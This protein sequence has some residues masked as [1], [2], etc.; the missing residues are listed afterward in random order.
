MIDVWRNLS[1]YD[2]E[3]S[4]NFYERFIFE[5]LAR[6]VVVDLNTELNLIYFD[7]SQYMNNRKSNVKELMLK[8]FLKVVG[9]NDDVFAP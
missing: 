1:F 8:K 4:T 2:S 5:V 6:S 3:N 9:I 7:F